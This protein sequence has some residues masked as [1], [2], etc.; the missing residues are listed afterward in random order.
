MTARPRPDARRLALASAVQASAV[1]ASAA[2]V[3][4]AVAAVA[5][6][7]GV[8]P[9]H[10]QLGTGA[11][12]STGLDTARV[13]DLSGALQ[14]YLP[15]APVRVAGVNWQVSPSIGVD[16]GL[17]DN[18]FRVDSP[19]RAD[20]F[21]LITPSILVTGDTSRVQANLSYSPSISIYA[22]NSSQTRVDQFGQAGALVTVVPDTFFVDLRGSISESSLTG[23]FGA[24]DNR[25][26]NQN[27]QVTTT[28]LSATPYVQ[29]RFRGWGT[30]V[31]SY[32]IAQTLQ[33]TPGGNVTAGAFGLPAFYGSTGNLTT[34]TER[35]SFTTGENFGRINNSTVVSATQFDGAGS[36]RGA[37][38]N[39]VTSTTS[40]ALTRSFTALATIG[41]QSLH[42]SGLPPYNINGL[43]YNVGGRYAPNPN[44]S[45][46]LTYGRRDGLD[47]FA[48]DAS[49]FP[50]ARTALFLRYSTGL[51]SSA[52]DAQSLLSTTNVGANGLLTDR[53]TGAPVSGGNG[54]F[55]TQ[56]NIFQV[57][58][59][60]LTGLLNLDRDSFSANVSNERR[61]SVT[62][63]AANGAVA[64]GTTAAP[65]F[66]IVPAGV[67]TTGTFGSVTWG[68]QLSDRLTSTVTASYGVNDNGN[69]LGFGSGSQTSFTGSAGLSYIFSPTLT[70]RVIYSHTSVSGTGSN[71]FGLNGQGFNTFG[72]RSG[73]Y[74]ENVL[75]A[76]LRKSF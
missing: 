46:T 18:A 54:F 2:R 59:V 65:G 36:Y 21:T 39:E 40:Y 45:A 6:V 66:G 64:N 67:T 26:F 28:A 53:G 29:H 41:Y 42:Y 61:T 34:Q 31:A 5:C 27:N 3:V 75:L 56:N 14:S 60:S 63:A 8:S 11:L 47:D 38:R 22:N 17:T 32:T 73:S 68:H 48:A 57:R 10:A 69:A 19:R 25:G 23:G 72:N 12:P 49:W 4:A 35:V 71:L 7:A 62:N 70:G 37:Y 50:T 30:G 33:D 24:V 74:D 9:A 58:R 1:Q 13:G 51:T 52:Q 15:G 20:V 43:I 55:G 16:V 76:G 44:L